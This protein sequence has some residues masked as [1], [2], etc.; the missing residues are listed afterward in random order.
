MEIGPIN[1]N[2]TAPIA[3]PVVPSDRTAEHRDV[4]QAV[5]A[6]NAAGM[7]GN[8]DELVFQRDDKTQRMVVRLVN[9]DTKEVVSQVPPEYVLRLAEDLR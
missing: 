4:V 2:M 9:K 6:L 8:E 5:K 7:F 1:L 3:A